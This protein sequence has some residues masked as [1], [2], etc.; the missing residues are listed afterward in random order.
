MPVRVC[1]PRRLNPR[2]LQLKRSNGSLARSGRRCPSPAAGGVQ[3]GAHHESLS[4]RSNAVAF[5]DK[6]GNRAD[7]SIPLASF[8]PSL[9]KSSPCQAEDL[10]NVKLYHACS[11]A[12]HLESGNIRGMPPPLLLLLCFAANGCL[13]L[14]QK[15]SQSDSH[16][17]ASARE[18]Y[19]PKS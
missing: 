15:V 16:C 9:K 4:G 8:R 17:I 10:L 19:S 12:A 18:V 11:A 1:V 7:Q 13:R 3:G 6:K 5:F 2:A 14:S